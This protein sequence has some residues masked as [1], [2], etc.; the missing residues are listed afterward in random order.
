MTMN[1]KIQIRKQ[2]WMN[3]TYISSRETLSVKTLRICSEKVSPVQTPM[4]ALE[5]TKYKT[6]HQWRRESVNSFHR[7][8]TRLVQATA[9]VYTMGMTTTTTISAVQANLLLT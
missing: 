3:R 7:L 8:Q 9:L 6:H 1:A 2:T 4:Q 5:R